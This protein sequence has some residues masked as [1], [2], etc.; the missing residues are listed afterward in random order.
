MANTKVSAFPSGIV[1]IAT[2][3]V[4][5]VQG[6][7]SVGVTASQLRQ[8]V[9]TGL[10]NAALAGVIGV[11]AADTYLA[12]SAITIPTAGGWKAGTILRWMFDMSKS[13]AGVGAFTVT[14]RMGTLGTTGDA[15]ILALAFGAGTALGDIG[16]FECNASFRTVGAGTTATLIASVKCSHHLA[17]TGLIS[18]GA[19]GIGIVTNVSAGFN[20]TT[21]TIAGLSINGGAAFS[22]T[23]SVVIGWADNI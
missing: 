11:Y 19:A 22:G 8:Y 6:G 18:T 10:N 7:N 17:A 9:G 16:W 23:T 2:D 12:G 14:I 20:S 4:G 21:Q 15:A 5:M 13:A 1:P 3:K